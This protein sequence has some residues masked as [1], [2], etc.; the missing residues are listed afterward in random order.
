MVKDVH[1]QRA[2]IVIILLLKANNMQKNANMYK[3]KLC[4]PCFA[5]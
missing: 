3:N 1:I 4:Y 2:N 5:L